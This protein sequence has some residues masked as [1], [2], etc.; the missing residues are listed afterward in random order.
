MSQNDFVIANAAG[1]AV[2]SDM[3]SAFQALASLS[4]GASAPGTTYANQFWHDDTNDLLKIR[5]EANTAWITV[6]SKVTT[7][8]KPYY[9][10]TILGNMST[11]TYSAI[12]Q[13]LVMSAKQIETARASVATAT[14][15]NL[16][17]A[18]ANAIEFTGTTA[19]TGFTTGQNG[20]LY[21]CSYPTGAGFTLTHNATSLILP[22]TANIVVAAGDTW[23]QLAIGSNNVRV[24]GYQR[25][26]GSSLGGSIATQ[27]Q[28]EAAS[29]TTTSASPGRT[30]YHP[31]VLKVFANIDCIGTFATR[32][33]Y[34]LTSTTDNGAGRCQL[35][36]ATDFSTADWVGFACHGA[37]AVGN[38]SG[39]YSS[40]RSTDTTAMAAG[41]CEW[42][43][44]N[45][46]TGGP[47]DVDL[48]TFG[49]FGDQ[50]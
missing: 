42:Q 2:R 4:G 28:M 10:G 15:P 46:P 14:T 5:D 13:A 7:V 41:T 19:V 24:F 6:A 34:N 22:T 1:A 35:N 45:A 32:T 48:N 25:A 11:L 17:T 37:I 26:D 29:S 40:Y 18:A 3:N 12:A 20:T 23:F 27:A 16:V 30:Q 43:I 33:S 47:T 49:G 8:W 31:G 21:Y 9:D 39:G 38:L 50:A 36:I 44:G